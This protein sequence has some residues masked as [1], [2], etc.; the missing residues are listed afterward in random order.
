M[1]RFFDMKSAKCKG[2]LS[3]VKASFNRR[4]LSKSVKDCYNH[5]WEFFQV[6]LQLANSVLHSFMSCGTRALNVYVKCDCFVSLRLMAT[7]FC[8][9]SSF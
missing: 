6:V 7:A 9:L 3:Q 8:L 5:A 2:T 4:N 1:N